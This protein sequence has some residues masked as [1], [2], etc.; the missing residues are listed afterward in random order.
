V[1]CYFELGEHEFGKNYIGDGEI[2]PPMWHKLLKD[3]KALNSP[4]SLEV[5]IIADGGE[6]KHCLVIHRVDEEEAG[7]YERLGTCDLYHSDSPPMEHFQ[8]RSYLTVKEWW[9]SREERKLECGWE[10]I[11][12][13]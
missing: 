11:T 5:M 7:T 4:R 12:L 8:G 9:P 13:K 6:R 1:E 10:T 3:D 2:L